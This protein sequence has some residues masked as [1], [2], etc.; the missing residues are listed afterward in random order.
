MVGTPFQGSA[1]ANRLKATRYGK[2]LLGKTLV[3]WRSVDVDDLP[4]GLEVGTIAGTS[5]LGIGRLLS[6]LEDP[7]DGTVS[8]SETNVPFATDRLMLHV[9]HSEML[10]SALVT[11]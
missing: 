3:Q 5:P 6:R 9:T 1:P 2:L 10:V 7:H 11:A 8:F 4:A